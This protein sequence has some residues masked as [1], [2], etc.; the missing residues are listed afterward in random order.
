MS[1]LK[2]LFGKY[3]TFISYAFFGICTTLVN[4]LLY[5]ISARAIRLSTISATVIAWG[6]A[7]LFAY[8]TNRKCVFHSRVTKKWDIIVE[9]VTFF[10]CRITTGLLD[11]LIMF[12][13]V[14]VLACNDVIM[15]IASNILVIIVNYIASKKVIFRR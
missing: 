3:R 7:V 4:I 1:E 5:Y 11:V 9:L 8:I 2:I 14:D 6:G 12:L 10:V 15:K 13:F